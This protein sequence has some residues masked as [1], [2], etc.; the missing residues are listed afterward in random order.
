MKNL[1][2]EKAIK[3]RVGGYSYSEIRKHIKVSKSSLSLW[4][5]SVGLTTRQKQRLTKK[6]WVAIRKGWEKWRNTRKEKTEIVSKEAIQE[7]NKIKI[8]DEKLFLMGVMLYWAEGTKEKEYN[9]GQGV[10]FNNSDYKMI[11]LFLKWLKKCLKLSDDRI[12]FDIYIHENNKN[13]LDEVKSFWSKVTGF[14]IDKFGKIYFKKHRINTQRKNVNDSY[15]GLLRVK[16]TKSTY[17]NRRIAGWIEGI[18]NKW[19]IVQ[20]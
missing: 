14:S 7:I 17:L 11:Q 16:V 4:L 18:C 6:K 20:R 5:R 3:L 10:T 8:T 13:R 1:L 15:H 9:I 19:E 12:V 2:K